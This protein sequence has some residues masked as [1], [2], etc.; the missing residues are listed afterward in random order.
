MST[1]KALFSIV[2]ALFLITAITCTKDPVGP[3]IDNSTGTVKDVDGNVYTTVKIG[4]QEW[5]AENLR[6]TKY[7]DGSA[8]T[9]IT[10]GAT[11]DSCY[12][13]NIPAYCY[14]NNTINIDSIKKYGALYNWYAVSPANPKKIAP[15]GWHVPT[16]SEW[17]VLENYLELNGYNWD[18]TITGN[19]VAKSLA[20]KTDWYTHS[21]TG[22]I[23]NDLTQNNNSGFSALPGGYRD[24]SGFHGVGYIGRWWS[25][26]EDDATDAWDLSLSY[27][28]ADLVRD[29]GFESFASS[30][31]LLRDN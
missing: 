7:N 30:V 14:Y 15:T 12:Y 28:Q 22:T 1:I 8:I 5:M 24:G 26:T 23:G 21:T 9:N 4:A 17:T 2:V 29:Y 11:W 27:G 18:R 6:V 3:N 16:D 25:S 10:S 13:T 20:A 31:R 19:K